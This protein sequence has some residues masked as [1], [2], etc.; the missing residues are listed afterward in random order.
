MA[1]FILLI[2]SDVLNETCKANKKGEKGVHHY[3]LKTYFSLSDV[4]FTVLDVDSFIPC[5]I[6]VVVLFP[7]L[8]PQSCQKMHVAP[9]IQ[10]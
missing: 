5:I 1:F 3:F 2:F 8:Y 6:Y 10:D 4:Y 9:Q 7:I